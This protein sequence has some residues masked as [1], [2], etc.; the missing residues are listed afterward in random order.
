MKSVLLARTWKH[1][2]VHRG[3]V[4]DASI[5]KH[6]GQRSR[7]ML[8]EDLTVPGEAHVL[9]GNEC[10]DPA[11]KAGDEGTL[12]FRHNPH[13]PTG[14]YWQFRANPGEV[15]SSKFQGSNKAQGPSPKA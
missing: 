12:T 15:S 1:G 10:C 7:Y 11:A 2:T 8:V 3:R 4:L 5:V 9:I 14:G 13:A 6:S